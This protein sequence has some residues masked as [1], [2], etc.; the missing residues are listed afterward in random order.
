MLTVASIQNEKYPVLKFYSF[1]GHLYEV[2]RRSKWK[3]RRILSEN[4][5][6]QLNCFK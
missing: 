1:P 3:E 4:E 2:E 6:L 5:L